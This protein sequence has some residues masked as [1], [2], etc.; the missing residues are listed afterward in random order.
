MLLMFDCNGCLFR[1]CPSPSSEQF[2]RDPEIAGEGVEL[3]DDQDIELRG[4]GIGQ[5]LRKRR[6]RCQV[7][8]PGA[9][10]LVSILRDDCDTMVLA[11]GGDRPL[12]LRDGIA[13]HL[14][15]S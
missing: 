15:I 12:L 5:H 7:I 9:P 14:L 1:D 6:A 4:S 8:G 13:L 2:E 3:L 10:L 11:I